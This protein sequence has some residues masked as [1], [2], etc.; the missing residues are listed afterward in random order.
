ME[1]AIAFLNKIAEAEGHPLTPACLAYLRKSIKMKAV[2]K[3][4]HLLIE[5]QVCENLYFIMTGLL[6]SY[7]ILQVNWCV[8]G[9][10]EKWK[11]WLRSIAFM[12]RSRQRILSKYWR[13]ACCFI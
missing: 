8:T 5:G 4:E 6:K 7:Y 11:Q 9:F 12:I 13:I 10:S 1:E 2:K 3:D